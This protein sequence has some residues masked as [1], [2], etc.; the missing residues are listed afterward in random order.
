M[1]HRPL[2]GITTFF[3]IGIFTNYLVGI[4]SFIVLP[5]IF[6]TIIVFTFLFIFH[7]R[8]SCL[9]Q[10]RLGENAAGPVRSGVLTLLILIFLTGILYHHF[11]SNPNPGNN[12]SNIISTE[13]IP[14]Y[15]RGVVVSQPIDKF[16]QGLPL[17]SVVKHRKKMSNFLLRVEAVECTSQAET[18]RHTTTKTSYLEDFVREIK[19]QEWRNVSGVIKVNVYPTRE[20]EKTLPG[21]RPYLSDELNYGDKVELTCKISIPSASRN[22]GQ[23]DYKNYL[24]KQRPRID[25]VA[26]VLSANNIKVLSEGNGNY[27]FTF[28]YGL[29]KQ[30][31]AVIERHVKEGS[32]PLVNSILLGDREKVPV[33]LMDGFLQTGTIHFLAISGL[34]VG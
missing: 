33:N 3:A 25:A 24:K 15:L 23:F 9:R 29:K 1:T 32:I 34:H 11:R 8:Q 18:V 7:S 6:L 5:A 20:E 30:L 28:V 17:S 31:N 21:K 22:P 19:W 27:F 2:V 13:K 14:I 26:S 16:V 10:I 4:P 12:I